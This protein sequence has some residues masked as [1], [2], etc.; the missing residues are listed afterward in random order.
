MRCRTVAV[1]G[2]LLLALGL[3]AP[4]GWAGSGASAFAVGVALRAVEQDGFCRV[5]L[6]EGAF[7]A[8][9]VLVCST[10]QVADIAALDR[11]RYESGVHGGAYRF[12]PWSPGHV[13]ELQPPTAELP[14]IG[15]P[16]AEMRVVHEVAGVGSV[17][18]LEL[19]L[20]F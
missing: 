12:L 1:R 4:A 14:A 5:S 16:A 13:G 18:V 19:T 10:G 7:G 17:D 8:R 11:R 9:V 20:L 6:G 3:S 15:R 2:A